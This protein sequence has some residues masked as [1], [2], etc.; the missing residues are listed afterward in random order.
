[1]S[2]SRS[3]GWDAKGLALPEN[4]IRTL[5]RGKRVTTDSFFRIMAKVM[6]E[7]LHGRMPRVRTKDENFRTLLASIEKCIKRGNRVRARD[8]AFAALVFAYE[9]TPRHLA[10]VIAFL[11]ENY[12]R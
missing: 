6:D 12:Q 7:S 10:Q 2:K 4:R 1:M 3:L 9:D 8:T 11:K 5:V